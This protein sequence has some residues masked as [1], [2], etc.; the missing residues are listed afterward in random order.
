LPDDGPVR[1]TLGPSGVESRLPPADRRRER[2]GGRRRRKRRQSTGIFTPEEAER[3]RRELQAEV[4]R[5]NEVLRRLGHRT[6]LQLLP[7]RDGAPDRVAICYPQDG[8]SGA[9]CVARTVR[10]REM[11]QWLARLEGLEGLVVDT[12]R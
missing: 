12:E 5:G 11:Q 10:F 6:A 2:S 9:R 1:S 4:E 8:S 3:A 7:G